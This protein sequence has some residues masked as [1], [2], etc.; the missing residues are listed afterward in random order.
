MDEY[1]ACQADY[2]CATLDECIGGSGSTSCVSQGLTGDA[3]LACVSACE[4]S[5]GF[6]AVTLRDA[7]NDCIYCDGCGT[8]KPPGTYCSKDSCDDISDKCYESDNGN[9][10]C[11]LCAMN[12]SCK[13]EVAACYAVTACSALDNCMNTNCNIPTPVGGD[14]VICKANCEAAYPAGIAPLATYQACI[15]CDACPISCAR[16]AGDKCL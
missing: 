12:T 14:W 7:L 13:D 15:Y 1:A 2:A 8:T 6:A 5:A 16:D 9:F 3:W 11:W 10:S 4:T